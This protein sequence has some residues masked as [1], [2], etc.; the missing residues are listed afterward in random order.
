MIESTKPFRRA[1]ALLLANLYLA[2]MS[3]FFSACRGMAKLTRAHF[4]ID[5]QISPTL[6]RTYRILYASDAKK[7]EQESQAHVHYLKTQSTIRATREKSAIESSLKQTRFKNSL[8]LTSW[9]SDLMELDWKERERQQEQF[10]K[11]SPKNVFSN[12]TYPLWQKKNKVDDYYEEE[13]SYTIRTVGVHTAYVRTKPDQTSTTAAILK[14][15]T[16]VMIDG[17]TTGRMYQTTNRWFRVR[18]NGH[19]GGWIWAGCLTK[20]STTGI[21]TVWYKDTSL[22][23]YEHLDKIINEELMKLYEETLE[24]DF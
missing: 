15:G 23:D 7:R 21:P 13:D 14:A 8:E 9:Q 20:N 3:I 16:K 1:G 12:P 19:L 2:S 6:H 11:I 24:S 18:E 4:V 5:P 22:N 17:Y 10:A